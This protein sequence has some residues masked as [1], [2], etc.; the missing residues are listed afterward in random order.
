MGSDQSPQRQ[1]N[2]QDSP[3]RPRPPT[4]RLG[5]SQE[6]RGPREWP[7]T[8]KRGSADYAGAFRAPRGAPS[9]RDRCVSGTTQAWRR[10]PPQNPFVVADAA[11]NASTSSIFFRD[12]LSVPA[13]Q[14]RRGRHVEQCRR[15]QHDHRREKKTPPRLPSRLRTRFMP[16]AGR[17]PPP[18]RPRPLD[19][20]LARAAASPPPT[21]TAAAG[22]GMFI[23]IGMFGGA[24]RGAG[25]APR[26]ARVAVACAHGE[27]VT[28]PSQAAA[29]ASIARERRRS[30]AKKYRES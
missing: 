18:S 24:V 16:K 9:V 6:P 22:I 14:R 8:R 25:A 4:A 17:S 2:P 1:K 29:L 11:A 20:C 21:R 30:P 5:T 7:W 15:F 3:H 23:K 19:S 12:P 26:V 28:L 27:S 10:C 13:C